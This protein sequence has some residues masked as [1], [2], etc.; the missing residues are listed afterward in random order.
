V[1]DPR[2]L[3]LQG[4]VA[5]VALQ[6]MVAA[7]AYRAP[8]SLTARQV[9]AVR[10]GPQGEA[11]QLDALLPGEVF[12][13]LATDGEWA[14]GQARRDGY[15]G[16]ALRCG[17]AVDASTPTH[18]VAAVRSLAFAA[19]SARAAGVLALPM[20]SLVRIDDVR[21][22]FARCAAHGWIPQAHLAPIGRFEAD[23]AAVAER[24]VGAP[25]LWGGRDGGG[26]DC[27]G[28]VQ[29]ALYAC[30]AACPRDSDQQARLGRP[31]RRETL[32]R[33]DLVCWPGHIG[34][35]L[36]EAL[37]V[38]ASGRQMA[39]VVEPLADAVAARIETVGEPMA[40]RRIRP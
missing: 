23:P 19:P 1:S 13:V 35:M 10:I 24:F 27:S 15:V 17:L 36:D 30:G 16:W 3:L 22:G 9:L 11:E 31:I 34:L 25:Y 12:E 33:N 38:H 28:L 6:G 18:R 7:G 14:F 4:E 8:Q 26:I 29:A 21:D 39:V 20:N 32:R 40:Y 37:V 2:R 5:A